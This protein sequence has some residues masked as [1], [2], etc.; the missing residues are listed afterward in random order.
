MA[1]DPNEPPVTKLF[2]LGAIETDTS[3]TIQKADMPRLIPAVNNT[4]ES[5]FVAMVLRVAAALTG[6]DYSNDPTGTVAIDFP[7]FGE[8][9][10]RQILIVLTEKPQL[11]NPT[12]SPANTIDPN[13]Y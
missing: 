9:G 1:I 4:A 3:L 8:V 11:D 2:G 12:P 13:K 10:K 6:G 7:T 5:M